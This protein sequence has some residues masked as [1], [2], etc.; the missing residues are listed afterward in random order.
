M[1]VE[2]IEKRNMKNAIRRHHYRRLQKK[3]S[4]YWFGHEIKMSPRQLGLVV[5]TPH[6][7]SCLG[8]GNPRKHIGEKTMQERRNFQQD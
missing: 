3:R 2:N 5:A 6:P 1:F 7:C 8:C 4:W